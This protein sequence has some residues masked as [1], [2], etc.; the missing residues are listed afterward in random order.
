M[1]YWMDGLTYRRFEKRKLAAP[2]SGKQR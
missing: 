2:R 1:T